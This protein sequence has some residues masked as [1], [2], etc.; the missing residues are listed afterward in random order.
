MSNLQ[1]QAHSLVYRRLSASEAAK[2]AEID[3]TE[4]IT[5]GYRQQ[6]ATII[7]EAVNWNVPPWH[8][9]DAGGHSVARMVHESVALAAEGAIVLGAFDQERLVGIAVLRERLREQV[10]QLALLFVSNGYRRQGIARRL[11]REIVE[12]ARA[13]NATYL[14]VSAT[15]SESAVGFYQSQGF[16][17][18]AEPD[19]ELLALEPEDIHMVMEL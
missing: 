18:T 1:P 17:P 10:A 13:S 15:P 8:P 2:I 4:R 9:E 6:G 16:R 5:L 11:V 12:L 19:P 3:R 7:A 14:Y